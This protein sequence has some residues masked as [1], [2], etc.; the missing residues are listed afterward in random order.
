MKIMSLSLARPLHDGYQAA[1]TRRRNKSVGTM[2]KDHNGTR[3]YIRQKVHV[4]ELQIFR[5]CAL[6]GLRMKKRIQKKKPPPTP[7]VIDI[8]NTLL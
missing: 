1:S 2:K 6:N 3:M 5:A 4:I 7:D 8:F